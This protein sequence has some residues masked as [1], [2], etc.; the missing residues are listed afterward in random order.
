MKANDL[1]FL[2]II[3]SIFCIQVTTCMF[4]LRQAI[5]Q[6][7]VSISRSLIVF[8]LFFFLAINLL[9]NQSGVLKISLTS[10]FLFRINLHSR[11][12]LTIVDKTPNLCIVSFQIG[13]ISKKK[14][15]F[16]FMKTSL[17]KHFN[18]R[19]FCFFLLFFFF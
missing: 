2:L 3:N 8:F 6:S 13:F 5:H 12:F 7:G 1:D 10:R 14:V 11:R 18:R 15:C 4:L 16:F 9:N 17:Q 19:V